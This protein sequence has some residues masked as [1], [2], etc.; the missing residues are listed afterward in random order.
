V[1]PRLWITSSGSNKKTA[2]SKLEAA[3]K[4]L[5]K[6]VWP[7]GKRLILVQGTTSASFFSSSTRI[8]T[9]GRLSLDEPINSLGFDIAG[10]RQILTTSTIESFLC[11]FPDHVGR[12][13]SCYP[14]D[15]DEK[16]PPPLSARLRLQIFSEPDSRSRT[17]GKS[18][19][20]LGFLG[21]LPPCCQS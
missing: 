12:A 21:D 2:K 6:V 7:G 17:L 11:R 15:M 9:M 16:I 19:S 10:L 13:K 1:A 20:S 8:S 3:C 4:R 5:A 18:I 14:K